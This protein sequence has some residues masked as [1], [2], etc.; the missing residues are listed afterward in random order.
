MRKRAVVPQIPVL[1][2][3]HVH[4]G[5]D[6]F[7]RTSPALFRQQMEM[8]IDEGYT[9][10][11][12]D[13]LLELAS[14]T[15]DRRYVMVTFDDAYTDFVDYA[16]PILQALRIPAT[17]FVISDAIG[18]WNDW[19]TI[20]WAPH[21]HLDADAL[22]RLH[23]QGVHIGSHSRTHRPLIRLWGSRLSGELHGSQHAL[24]EIIGVPVRTFAYPGGSE[25]WHVRR[26][27]R[28]V[29][30]LAFA[31]NADCRGA[32]CDR[33]RIPRFDPCFCGDR[34]VYRRTLQAHCGFGRGR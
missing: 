11:G 6:D 15:A 8:L 28:S 7:F 16:W 25:S 2:Y 20:R 22:R 13:R 1:G 12:P 17:L 34:N 19:D 31:T 32:T 10:I 14:A 23:A 29:Y 9:P 4:D 30:D 3:H 27:T 18:G 24:Q 26:A 5:A 33:Y 21:R